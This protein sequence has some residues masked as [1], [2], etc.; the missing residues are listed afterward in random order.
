MTP[1]KILIKFKKQI[2][3]VLNID[4]LT[5]DTKLSITNMLSQVWQI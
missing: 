3:N 1:S 2:I 5:L 4:F